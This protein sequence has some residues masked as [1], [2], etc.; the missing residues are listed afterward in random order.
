MAAMVRDRAISP[1]ELVEAHLREIEARNP[2]I[3]AFV[4]VFAEEAIEAARASQSAITRGDPLGLLH[5]VPVTVKDAFDIAG[6]G[7]VT[8]SRLRTGH[9]AS[10]DSAAVARLRAAGAILL[11]RTNT[12]ELLANRE[13]DNF[14]T[15]RSNN[16]W[17]LNRTPG[18]SSGGEAAAIAAFCS[19]G[20]IASDGGG[21]IRVPAHF[22]GIAGLKPT[23]GR[24]P[25]TG[26]F[27]SLGNPAGL[28][29]VAGPM[30]RT[31]QDLRLL[32]SVLASF[33]EADPF[34]VPAPLV[35]PE[36]HGARIGVWPRFYSAPADP[37]VIAAVNQAAKLLAVCGFH[38]EPF[39]PTGL[40]RAP[41]VWGMLF[42]WPGLAARQIYEGREGDAHWTL[43]EFWSDKVPTAEQLLQ[44]LATRDRLR[45]AFLRQLEDRAA[46][47]M[48]VCGVPAFLHRQ[49]SWELEGQ[50]AGM[51]PLMAPSVLANLL[52]LPAVTIPIALSSTGL[53]IG[54]QL[55][56]RPF[57]DELLL[58]L[59]IH[60]EEARGPWTGPK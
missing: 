25:V 46:I 40:E 21:S 55:M 45:A 54:V 56:G 22:C 41:S 12:P 38:A 19:P 47:L 10:Q 48:P 20:G 24:I 6:Q 36:S 28:V 14:I 30:A 3:N 51:A 37:E 18:G 15:G 16:P 52:G 57:G 42:Q 8:G 32:F 35:K 31:A 59:A 7:T 2:E 9:R 58:D 29:T 60:M 33:D 39:E 23:P 1:L 11:G 17:D 4:T 43:T 5:G 13:S 34:G 27:P 50:S 26:H 49:R 44:H 53:P